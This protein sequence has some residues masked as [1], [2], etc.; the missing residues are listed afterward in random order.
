MDRLGQINKQYLLIGGTILLL[1][2]SYQL[3]FKNT[4]NAWSLHR[5]LQQD[6]SQS[7]DISTQPAYVARKN[8]NL[9]QIIKAYQLDSVT[10]RNNA[11]NTIARLAEQEQVKLTVIPTD[12]AIYHTPHF[13]IQKL[14]FEGGFFALLKLADILQSTPGIGMLRSASW[15][16]QKQSPADEKSKKLSLEIYMEIYR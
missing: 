12:D 14:N 5:Q 1:A 15:K 13:I 8:R 10:F 9:D 6:L 11:V 16:T 7:T 2:L 3:A 4:L